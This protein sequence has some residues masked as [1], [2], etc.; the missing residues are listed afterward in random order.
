MRI[1]YNGVHFD[2]G[3]KTNYPSWEFYNLEL[4]L[5]EFCEN[6]GWEFRCFNPDL[7]SLETRWN[8]LGNVIASFQPDYT[9]AVNFNSNHDIPENLANLLHKQD[10]KLIEFHCD[11]VR[12]F[13][14][15]SN[16]KGFV[17]HF[18]TT[19]SRTISWYEDKKMSVINSQYAV[20]S[21]YQDLGLERNIDVCF[22][23]Q[24]Y[25]W[26]EQ[27]IKLLRSHS[28]NVDLYGKFWNKNDDSE[29]ISF[30]KMINVLSRSKICLSFLGAFPGTMAPDQLKA[31]VFEATAL[32]CCVVS[33]PSFNLQDYFR[34]N[35]EVVV[36]EKISQMADQIKEL[37]ADN[38]KRIAIAKSGQHRT[39]NDHTWQK[40]FTNIFNQIGVA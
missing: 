16:R 25:G 28:V 22:I 38:N 34:E 15:L 32:G 9:F 36:S 3:I 1:L 13:L 4:G 26:R 12:R 20:S 39:L 30:E 2:Y 21:A 5:K 14:E 33:T 40:R 23:G 7:Y 8:E 6:K 10:G 18:I 11:P 19:D 31:R 37:L 27:A 35:E 17:D 29:M 24:K